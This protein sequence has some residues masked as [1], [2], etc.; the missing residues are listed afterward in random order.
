[1][2][3][4]SKPYS[5]SENTRVKEFT[6]EAINTPPV[7]TWVKNYKALKSLFSKAK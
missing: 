6:V 7:D 2:K 4:K 1:M 3:E 5:A